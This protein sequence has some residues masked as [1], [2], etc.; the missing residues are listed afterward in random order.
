MFEPGRFERGS[1]DDAH[2]AGAGIA[3]A[4]AIAYN[5]GD[6]APRVVAKGKGAV[7]VEILKR[8]AEAG[9]YVHQS[10][11]L[12]QL[13]TRV[14]LDSQIPPELYLVIAEL[15]A[16]LY[17][18]D[19]RHSGGLSSTRKNPTIRSGPAKPAS[20]QKPSAPARQGVKK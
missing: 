5:E 12:V 15:L 20:A 17:R 6:L 7:A 1:G 16:W 9:V 13:L 2:A 14:D 4:V 18:T 11:E 8:A 19:A 10:R 3:N